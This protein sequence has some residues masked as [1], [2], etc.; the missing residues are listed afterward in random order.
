MLRKK[1]EEDTLIKKAEEERLRRQK[2]EEEECRQKE[3]EEKERLRKQQEEAEIKKNE[4][5]RQKKEDLRLRR[6]EEE[7]IRK[8]KE[9]QEKFKKQ[10]NTN[11]RKVPSKES[12]TSSGKR[13]LVFSIFFGILLIGAAAMFSGNNDNN[14]NQ[15]SQSGTI[16]APSESTG[17][18]TPQT[19]TKD[20]TVQTPSSQN[21]DSY[22]NSIGMEF[23]KIPAGEFM[24]GSPSSEKDSYEDESPVHKVTIKESYYLGKFEV[25]QKQWNTVM[26]NNPSNFKGDDLPV[27]MVHWND[28]QDF[29]KA[30]SDG[31]D[32]YVPFT[33]RSRMG[34]CLPCRDNNQIFL[35]G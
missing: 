20:N 8:E 15:E 19:T 18:S 22:T 16:T 27:E 11:E 4:Q 7:K 31:R 28:V 25:T 5:E 13:I 33:F 29:I 3:I 34:I 12:K 30:E 2:E 23:V 1:Q 10:K 17:G 24:M 21:S 32:R 14:N 35:W 6:E 9:E 26:D